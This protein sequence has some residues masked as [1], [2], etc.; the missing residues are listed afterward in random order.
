MHRSVLHQ[1]DESCS[2]LPF[3]SDLLRL[4]RRSLSG[5][6]PITK[7]DLGFLLNSVESNAYSA[8]N[9]FTDLRQAEPAFTSAL[10][11]EAGLPLTGIEAM[12]KRVR[13]TLD[14]IFAIV[15]Q[16][17]A[18]AHERMAETESLPSAKVVA[19][20]ERFLDRLALSAIKLDRS[21]RITYAN[22]AAIALLGTDRDI[23]GL[24]VYDIFPRTATVAAQMD[25]R[26]VG[27]ANLYET[28][29]FRGPDRKTV[30]VSIAGTPILDE[31]G[32]YAGTLG[33]VRSIEREKISEAIHNLME[34]ESDPETLLTGVAQ[35]IG[36]SVPFDYFG[37]S[38]FSLSSGHVSSFCAYTA[39]GSYEYDR[40]WWPISADQKLD[41]DSPQIIWEYD[42]YV[43]RRRPDFATDPSLKKFLELNFLSAIRIPVWREDRL[44]AS[45]LLL[46]RKPHFYTQEHLDQL[47]ALPLEQAVQ[48]A[49]SFQ[50]HRE[51]QFRYQLFRRATRCASSLDLANM[52]ATELANHYKWHHVALFEVCEERGMFQ[53]LAEHFEH[54]GNALP[55]EN[56]EQPLDRG[57]LGHVYRTRESVNIADVLLQDLPF[58]SGW[59]GVSSEICLPL[60]WEGDVHWLINV[61]DRRVDAFS[62]DEEYDLRLIVS[63]AEFLLARMSR[64][65]LLESAFESSSDAV[66]LTDMRAIIV[67]ANT[68]AA[69]LLGFDHPQQVLGSFHQIF[70]DEN[71]A[72]KVFECTGT[73]GGEMEIQR[74]D[75][76]SIPVLITAS[77]L[78][79]HLSR[80]LF[81]V[82]DLRL[83]KRI[84]KLE[85]LKKLFDEVA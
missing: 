79:R 41:Y 59:A 3:S 58:V 64:Q 12:E 36:R 48:L 61:E 82:K 15:L 35:H 16:E 40:R 50:N 74:S 19:L 8:S 69:K 77:R 24:S 14:D 39:N 23:R 55:L 84:E 45:I 78:P 75:G 66:F 1:S 25:K 71:E 20:E 68:A 46:S 27:E 73:F 37:I 2:H 10:Q 11:A 43:R 60:I 57:I 4:L 72:G 7:N 18:G 42:A 49:L 80:K 62:K 53:L 38:R 31:D 28:E 6:Q 21:F 17:T 26:R 34:T 67:S 51:S 33:I 63:D 22:P 5:A 13:S 30:P 83:I 29:I 9:L 70:K 47:R 32:A 56:H 65:H 52:L 76:S 81:T 44:V 85:G 54:P